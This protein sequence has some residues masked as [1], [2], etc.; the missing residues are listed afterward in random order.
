MC[1]EMMGIGLLKIPTKPGQNC[2][3]DVEHHFP[4]IFEKTMSLC[5]SLG[6][7]PCISGV[8]TAN[9]KSNRQG[10]SAAS[11][12]HIIYLRLLRGSVNKTEDWAHR[13]SGS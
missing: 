8:T 6:F 7:D 10:L 9:N 12:S 1:N 5:N 3:H 11:V 4:H 2:P 13:G